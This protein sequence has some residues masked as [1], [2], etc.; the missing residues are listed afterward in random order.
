MI[1]KGIKLRLYPN[2]EQELLLKQMCENNRFV[3][4]TLNGMLRDRYE[5]NKDLYNGDTSKDAKEKRKHIMLSG[6]DMDYLL[7][8]LKIEYPF[9]TDSDSSSLQVVTSNLNTAYTNFFKNPK[10]FG[11]P[12]FKRRKIEHLSYT[13][14]SKIHITG[15]RYLKVPK[16]GYIKTSKT[17][18]LDNC[19]IKRY[20]VE[21]DATKRWYITFQ[22]E[23][24]VTPFEKTGKIIGLDLG[25]ND[26]ICGSDG[27]QSGRFLNKDLE[28]RIATAHSCYSKR[29]HYAAVKISID[30]HQKVINPRSLF[31]FSNVE[32]AR[33]TKAKL[34]RRLA[35]QRKDFLHKLSTK[36]VKE[37]DVIVIEDLPSTN[38]MKNHR[39]A[40]SIANAAWYE[41]RN[42]LEYK[43]A[44][45]G[46]QLIIVPPHYT[47]QE[48][49]HCQ[50][51]G[52]QKTLDIREW[53][54]GNC[55]ATHHRDVNA[56]QNILKKGL[57]TLT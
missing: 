24:A 42:M 21:R 8:Q 28:K 46:K 44:W 39:L 29:R 27:Y 23:I 15:N 3:W 2:K 41:F 6:I 49:S 40:K 31:D 16:L 11:K 12:R 43:C 56:A 37:N 25:L 51:R 35:N 1:L 18:R 30:K 53:T 50:H 13:G 10:Q 32:R 52:G 14:K 55:G 36:I 48:C 54:C 47:S 34:Q 20:T 45:Y 33:V 17:K 22:V 57:E 26:M 7:P 4:N 19:I 38:M 9:L 5:N